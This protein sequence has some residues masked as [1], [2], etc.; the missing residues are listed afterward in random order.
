MNNIPQRNPPLRRPQPRRPVRLKPTN[1]L[2]PPKLMQN[3]R[4]IVIQTYKLPLYAL[5]SGDTRHK[6][7]AGCD[8]ED[9]VIFDRLARLEGFDAE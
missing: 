2:N 8:P 6:L 4:D 3:P 5:Q 1:N 7:G 9:C